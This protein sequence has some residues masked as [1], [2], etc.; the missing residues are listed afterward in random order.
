ML[1]PLEWVCQENLLL[2]NKEHISCTLQRLIN[3]LIMPITEAKLERSFHTNKFPKSASKEMSN[4]FLKST[5]EKEDPVL[6][7]LNTQETW[8]RL[9]TMLLPSTKCHSIVL[10]STSQRDTLTNI[11]HS[12]HQDQEPTLLQSQV[13]TKKYSIKWEESTT[14]RTHTGNNPELLATV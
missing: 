13:R 8:V 7:H 2:L 14:N 1:K 11:T 5:K 3:E 10:R 6:H 12:K 9:A 4:L